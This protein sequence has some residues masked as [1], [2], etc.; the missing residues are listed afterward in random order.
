LLANA[1]VSG[2]IIEHFVSSDPLLNYRCF[3]THRNGL[4]FFGVPSS[5]AFYELKERRNNTVSRKNKNAYPLE[6][7]GY[8]RT[9]SGKYG[10]YFRKIIKENIIFVGDASGGAGNIHGMIQGQF[11]GTV[12]ASAIEDNDITEERLSEYQNLV[13]NTLGK[14]P[15]LWLSARE[16]FGS[17][18]NW[19]REFEKLTKGIEA[20]EL[21]HFE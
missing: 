8:T 12:A 19:F 7:I 15:F 2:G 17:F 20:T 1:D 18:H 13:H 10:E 5:A 6:I 21:G 4:C 9:S 11:A 3:F 14:A 16:D